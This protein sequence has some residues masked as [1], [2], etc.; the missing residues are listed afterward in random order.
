MLAQLLGPDI[1]AALHQDPG[2]LREVL[3]EIHVEDI[4]EILKE[5]P[6]DEALM[7]M[8]LMPV[9]MAA[10]VAVRVPEEVQERLLE[11]LE[12][13]RSVDIILEMAADDRAGLMRELPEELRERLLD[14][15]YP[16]DPEVAQEVR[17][18]LRYDPETAGGLM[19]TEY[20]ALPPEMTAQRAIDAVRRLTREEDVETIYYIYVVDWRGRLVGVLSLRDLILSDADEPLSE[21]MTENVLKASPS[22]DQEEVANLMHKYDFAALPVVDRLNKMLGVVTVDD[23]FDVVIEEA[24]E[25]AQKMGA[26]EPIE[27]SYFDTG[28]LTLIRKRVSWLVVLFAGELLTATVMEHYEAD[29]AMILDLALFIP[30]I[31]S[32]GGNSGAQSSSLVIRAMALGEMQPHDWG[33]VLR[34][35]LGIG[36]SLGLILGCVGFLRGLLG[37]PEA[38]WRIAS[39]VAASLVAVVTLGSLIGSLLPLG[40]KRLGLDPAVSSTPFV[41]SLVD[42]L[43]L[44]VYFS[45]ARIFFAHML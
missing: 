37:N 24:T 18:L 4:A 41:A 15:I 23:V 9:E 11:R 30:L 3:E 7:L 25:D 27:E 22:T 17:A 12:L 6:E 33:R 29:L 39:T 1:Q 2:Q 16:Q 38:V 32:S 43:G 28:A 40:I 31:I 42:V 10:D 13:E 21:V 14:A 45:V 44:V 26:V 19:T 36:I 35:E 8:R 5:L 20:L 34:R